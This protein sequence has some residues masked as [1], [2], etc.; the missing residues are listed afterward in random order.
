L[1]EKLKLLLAR[2]YFVKNLQLSVGIL[3]EN[4]N[5]LLRQ[6]FDPRRRWWW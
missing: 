4:C 5:I 3:S 2:I 6:P 1:K